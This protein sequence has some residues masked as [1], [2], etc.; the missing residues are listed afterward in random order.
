MDCYVLISYVLEFLH[1]Y[2]ICFHKVD[3]DISYDFQKYDCLILLV[4][5]S[6]CSMDSPSKFSR[7]LLDSIGTLSKDFF[8]DIL[9][10]MLILKYSKNIQE[11]PKSL[12]QIYL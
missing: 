1:N 5:Q 11:E 7:Y 2:G 6:F 9:I 10:L 8:I 12:I 3:N 4:M